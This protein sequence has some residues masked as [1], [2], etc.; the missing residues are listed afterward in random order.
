MDTR[1]EH[2]H[3]VI[4]GG[5]FGGLEAAKALDGAAVDITLVDRVNYH[6]FQP[7][8]YQVAM[9]GL[10]PA[11]IASPI[12]SILAEQANVRVVLGNVKSVDLE[13]RQV[14]LGSEEH[15]TLDYDWLVLAVGAQTSYFGHDEW[16]VHAPGLK[17]LEDALEI[18]R[19]VLLAFERAEKERD[20]RIRRKL[21]TFVVIGGGPTGVEL[22]GAIAE[23]SHHVVAH[24]F[25]AVDPREA[26][27]VLVEAGPGILPAFSPSLAQ[28]AVEQ[29]QELGAEV[30]SGMR[31]V[32]IDDD[33]VELEDG[34]QADELP[35]LGTGRKRERIE[36]A[37]VVWAAGVRASG[38]APQ[39]G[40]PVD[41]QGRIIVEKDCSLPGHP[42]VFAI[43]DM[44][45]FEE[46]GTVLPGVSP[47]AM[48]QARYVAKILRWE[49]ESHG[50]P[51]REPFSYF[52]KGSM[53]T[54]GRSRAIA[55]AHG[56]KMHG[57]I[58]WLAWLFIHIWYLIGF[59]NRISVL[60]NWAWSYIS[61]KR[62]AR[63]ITS[64]GWKPHLEEE[65]EEQAA[66]STRH[67]PVAALADGSQPVPALREVARSP[68]S[69]R[70]RERAASPTS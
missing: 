16:E 1:R 41:K 53:A 63:L 37:T 54:I 20:A 50:R 34:G 48:Q 52:D 47:V 67:R 65:Q 25:R 14:Q 42:E 66:L 62:G 11:D 60:F 15:E 33:G 7:L 17:H 45:R 3:V 35:G 39:L 69:A 32:A 18:R 36:S 4:V 29:L 70:Q 10:S 27:V 19:R 40:A 43:G 13:A 44:A 12:R 55:E 38:L 51:P 21:L 30:R 59:K 22:A 57:F 24:D 2:K 26:K 28:S 31:V 9:A 56:L 61:Y 46:R 5:G 64:T 68:E 49:L 23:L 8:L 58:A 6:L